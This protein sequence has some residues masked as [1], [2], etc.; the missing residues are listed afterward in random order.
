M[1]TFANPD[2]SHGESRAGTSAERKS[3]NALKN[4]VEA[5]KSGMNITALA[6]TAGV[7]RRTLAW[8]VSARLGRD[9]GL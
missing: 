1:A 9:G 5:Y 8:Y 3:E 4:A 2:I 7:N 6:K